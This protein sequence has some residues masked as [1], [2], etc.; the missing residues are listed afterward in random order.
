MEKQKC[1]C[2]VMPFVS[3][4]RETSCCVGLAL[5]FLL[6]NVIVLNSSFDELWFG[7]RVKKLFPNPDQLFDHCLGRP[8]L[9]SIHNVN[10]GQN[11]RL[12]L[13]GRIDRE[14]ASLSL[15]D[16][17]NNTTEHHTVD[18]SC[19]D[20]L[21][22]FRQRFLDWMKVLGFPWTG[23]QD[24][25]SLWDEHCSMDGL[26]AMG[27]ALMTM[28]LFSVSDGSTPIETKPF[29]AAVTKAPHAFMSHD[30]LG[31][32]YYR[33]N[34]FKDASD[35]FKTAI[36]INPWGAGAM[37]GLMWCSLKSGNENDTVYW[38]RQKAICCGQDSDPAEQ[39]AAGLYQKYVVQ[40]RSLRG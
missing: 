3:Q 24:K 27:K 32:A 5:H 21:V 25:A 34:C 19:D 36:A 23:D 38:A 26:D 9:F 40:V 10:Q 8:S 1:Q 33:N 13:S 22:R 30:L 29:K 14:K 4:Q 2:I 17:Q 35:A 11:I 6:G 39:K 18:Y 12:W 28:Y 7:W 31:W 16:A 20:H 15:Y 37:S